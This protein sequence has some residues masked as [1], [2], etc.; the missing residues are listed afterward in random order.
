MINQVWTNGTML[1]SLIRL[2]G[3]DL[4]TA[5]GVAGEVTDALFDDGDWHLRFFVVDTGKH[6]GSRKILVSPH[7][8]GLP[9]DDTPALTTS[10][11]REQI[12]SSPDVDL[13]EPV[14]LQRQQQIH[15]HFDWPMTWLVSRRRIAHEAGGLE[16]GSHLRSASEV[17]SYT[18]SGSDEEV[19]RVSDFIIEAPTWKLR[20][21][22]VSPHALT[23]TRE[24]MLPT[25]NVT[26]VDWARRRIFADLSRSDIESLPKF[27]PTD[28][29]NH[30][31][32][33]AQFDYYG[34]STEPL[35]LA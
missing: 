13:A 12:N 32:Q 25:S 30:A 24:V 28:A 21:F 35:S 18:I 34:R 29:V 10:M 26:H 14:S 11:S 9:A 19:G 6:F 20:Y 16:P 15:E 33:E 27:D 2:N 7:A 23:A 1:R 17:Q 22:V 5:D 8:C 3:Y 4:R 31:F